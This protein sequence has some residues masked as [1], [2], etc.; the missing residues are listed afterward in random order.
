MEPRFEGRVVLVTGAGTGLGRA[1]AL[2]FARHGAAVVV[3]NR[4]RPGVPPSAAAVADQIRAEGGEALVSEHAVDDE[5]QVDAMVALAHGWRGRIDALVC[6]AAVVEY[7]PFARMSRETFRR[8]L[9]VNLFGSAFAL[10]A[11]LPHMLAAG[12]GRVVL[13]GSQVGLYGM[14]DNAAYGASKAAMVGLA[15]SVALETGDADVRVNVVIPAAYTRMSSSAIGE[16]GAER[17]SP[18]RVAP[19]TGWLA[20]EQCDRSGLVLH[21]AAGRVARARIMETAG[22]DIPGEDVGACWPALDAVDDLQEA[23]SAGEAGAR[24]VRFA[25]G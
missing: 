1:Y 12:Y 24:L 6:N 11:C 4:R 19:V 15:R 14:V 17:M 3:N 7:A 23:G 13:T 2:W 20:S 21:A 18:F 16:G 10:Q 5:A 22:V 25:T 9:E 8:I